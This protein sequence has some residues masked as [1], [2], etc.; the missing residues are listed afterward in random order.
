MYLLNINL[1]NCYGNYIEVKKF[2]YMLE[3]DILKEFSQRFLNVMRVA[4]ECPDGHAAALENYYRIKQEFPPKKMRKTFW[5][6]FEYCRTHNIRVCLYI[7]VCGSAS[8]YI[9]TLY[10]FHTVLALSAAATVANIKIR[11]DAKTPQFAIF[12]TPVICVFYSRSIFKHFPKKCFGL[13]V[14]PKIVRSL[15]CITDFNYL[16]QHTVISRV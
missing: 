7:I 9:K 8:L 5:H 6:C 11:Y 16:S 14:L 2:N 1:I 13:K 10:F 3:K 15:W 12:G 4:F